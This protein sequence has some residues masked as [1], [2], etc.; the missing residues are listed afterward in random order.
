MRTI[1]F[2][3]AWPG[4]GRL[5][6]MSRPAGGDWLADDLA[7]LRTS[8]VDT[9]V[10]AL[11]P[12]ENDRLD[13]LAQ[14]RLAADAGISFVAF[15]I[16][17]LGVPV[18]ARLQELAAQLADQVRAGRYVAAHC[19]AGIGRSSVIVA[20]T[21]IALG[22]PARQAMELIGAARGLAVPETAAQR[23]LLLALDRR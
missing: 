23:E 20:A 3:I 6:T 17:D 4:P 11:T 16:V 15:P 18:A 2:L 21:L 22:T 1:P 13:L 9:L 7:A 12:D 8:G 10:S 14:P 5:A 19:F